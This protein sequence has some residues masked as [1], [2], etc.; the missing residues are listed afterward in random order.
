LLYANKALGIIFLGLLFYLKQVIYLN[1]NY[2]KSALELAKLGIGYVN[3]NPLVG[4]V[5]VK[6][7]KIISEG[8]HQFYGGPHAEIN[9]FKNTTE[10]VKGAT[11]YVTLEPCSHYGKTPPCVQEIVKKGISKVVI[12]MKDP[13][14]IVSGKGIKILKENKIEVI[15][16]VLEEEAK[17]LNE[18]F[19]KYITEK[20]PFCILKTAMTLDGKIACYTGDSKWITN[21]FSRKYV[22]ELRHR[23]SGIMVGIE[24]VLMD[25]P[26]LTTR[27]EDKKGNS[28]TRIV[29]DSKGRIPLDSNVLNKNLE[30]NTIIATTEI[31]HKNKIKS[32]KEMGLDVIVTPIKD[33]KVDLNY[34]MKELGKIN[35]DS[36]LLEG[37]STLNYSALNEGIVDKVIFFIAPKILGGINAKT[38]VG[39]QGKEYVKD[40]FKLYDLEMSR[41]EDDFMI[42]GYIRKRE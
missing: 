22:H 31:A 6:D 20:V 39:G 3:P 5:I 42:Q 34:L 12:A 26:Q 18:I 16:G 27:L 30:G 7:G 15:Y 32:I 17:K 24:T 10:D 11:M 35:I 28:P 2:M 1:V 23:V 36:I 14:P 4:A 21:E 37:G 40:A 13:N 8:Y 38:P 9:A 29:V 33:N 25:N 19:I 41:F